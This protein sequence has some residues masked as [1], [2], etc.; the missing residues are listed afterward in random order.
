MEE[1]L[2]KLSELERKNSEFYLDTILHGNVEQLK[3]LKAKKFALPKI[4]NYEAIPAENLAYLK[5]EYY[6]LGPRSSRAETLE[7]WPVARA[8]LL[9][10]KVAY[11]LT[12]RELY[13]WLGFYYDIYFYNILY[14]LE[15]TPIRSGTQI[16]RLAKKA[17]AFY[18]EKKVPNK[19]ELAAK[20]AGRCH[21]EQFSIEI[22]DWIEKHQENLIKI[23]KS[24]EIHLADISLDWSDEPPLSFSLRVRH[25]SG[26]QKQVQI[27]SDN[28]RPK[29]LALSEKIKETLKSDE[30][31][32]V[33]FGY[34]VPL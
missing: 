32:E 33:N 20:L 28:N 25:D 19:A 31:I 17:V 18:T 14:D 26:T 21:S 4:E 34:Y 10:Q 5:S 30:R 11:N 23:I 13:A 29:E 12:F 24:F 9:E 15:S 6:W 1:F 27:D 7:D 16:S 22:D 3:I 8:W 2:R